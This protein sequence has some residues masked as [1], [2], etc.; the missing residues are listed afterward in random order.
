MRKKKLTEQVKR[1]S[2]LTKV[3]PSVLLNKNCLEAAPIITFQ[4]CAHSNACFNASQ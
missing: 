4:M 3:L 2:L 1:G